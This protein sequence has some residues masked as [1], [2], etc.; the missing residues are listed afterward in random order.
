MDE[1]PFR[2]KVGHGALFQFHVRSR[3]GDKPWICEN[4]ALF[5]QSSDHSHTEILSALIY[6]TTS[7]TTTAGSHEI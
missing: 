3:R 5:V 2:I 6:W 4:V 1:H 7:A